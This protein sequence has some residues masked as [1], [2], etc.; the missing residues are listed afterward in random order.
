MRHEKLDCVSAF[1]TVSG[2]CFI[3]LCRHAFL[4]LNSREQQILTLFSPVVLHVLSIITEDEYHALMLRYSFGHAKGHKR[5][6]RQNDSLN[7]GFPQPRL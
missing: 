3:F 6:L 5:N 2:L 7:L 4:C 1:L